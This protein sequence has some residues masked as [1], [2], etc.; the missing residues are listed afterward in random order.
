MALG[1]HQALAASC[2]IAAMAETVYEVTMQGATTL[3]ERPAEVTEATA[4]DLVMIGAAVV[5][6]HCAEGSGMDQETAG[7]DDLA[8]TVEIL[9]VTNERLR[10]S[11]GAM[12]QRC[13]P[14][15]ETRGRGARCTNSQL[16]DA[17]AWM[18]MYD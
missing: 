11:G 3:C 14:T 6:D 4:A 2:G 18:A 16:R 5:E 1:I 10:G 15:T 9:V 7:R 12:P 17:G 13:R 8:M